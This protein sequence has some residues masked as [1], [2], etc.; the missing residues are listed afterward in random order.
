LTAS[1]SLDRSKNAFE[2][3]CIKMQRR[4]G[5]LTVCIRQ[6]VPEGEKRANWIPAPAGPFFMAGRRNGPE[7]S[8]IHGSY[9]IPECKRV[10]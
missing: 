2:G 9:K 6:E 5:S 8:P 4:D 3:L 1:T 7:A 10:P